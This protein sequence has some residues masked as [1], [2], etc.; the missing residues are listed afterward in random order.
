MMLNEQGREM[1]GEEKW[2][3]DPVLLVPEGCSAEI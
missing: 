3:K 2:N 1:G